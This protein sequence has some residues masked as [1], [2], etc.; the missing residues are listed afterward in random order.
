M[1]PFR[2]A[3]REKKNAT[4]LGMRENKKRTTLVIREKNTSMEDM[5]YLMRG[6]MNSNGKDDRN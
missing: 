5:S 4:R 3:I 2:L 1:I 6:L